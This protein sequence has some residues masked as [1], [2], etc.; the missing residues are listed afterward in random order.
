MRKQMKNEGMSNLD[1][2]CM[3]NDTTPLTIITSIKRN[4]YNIT[5]VQIPKLHKNKQQPNNP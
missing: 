2:K 1:S 3:S 5:D 4:N